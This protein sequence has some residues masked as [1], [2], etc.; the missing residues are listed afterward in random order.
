MQVDGDKLRV[1]MAISAEVQI[2]LSCSG[3]KEVGEILYLILAQP[4]FVQ[5]NSSILL[6]L[7]SLY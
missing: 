7:S 2:L 5:N 4:Y 1:V 6:S 3:G